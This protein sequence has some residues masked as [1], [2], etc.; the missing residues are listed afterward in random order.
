[1]RSI[2]VRGGQVD[3]QGDLNGYEGNTGNT[4]RLIYGPDRG[5]H[6]HFTVFDAEGYRVTPGAYTSIYGH[7]SVPSGYTYNPLDFLGS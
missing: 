4:T 6:L 2:G 3:R 7:Y 5:Y 1:M